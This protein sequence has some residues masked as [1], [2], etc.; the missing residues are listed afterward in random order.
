M[1]K[2]SL[3]IIS[4]FAI[5]ILLSGCLQEEEK[6][7]EHI[8][9]P[10]EEKNKTQEN[11]TSYYPS[12][13]TSERIS[14]P[15]KNFELSFVNVGYGDATIILSK[16]KVILIDTAS[17]ESKDILMA[18]L[19]RR[20][21]K[22]IDLLILSAPEDERFSGNLKDIIDLYKID[23]IW[24]PSKIYLEK[25]LPYLKET[26]IQEVQFGKTYIYDKLKIFVLN[27]VDNNNIY[28]P[29]SDSLVLKVSYNELC[30]I[31]FSKSK[32]GGT[33]RGG[34]TNTYTLGTIESKF[35]LKA[36]E[37]NEPLKCD[38]IKLSD[39]GAGDG[40]SYTLLDFIKPKIGIISVGPNPPLNQ[41]P[42]EQM[43]N[44]LM[45]KGISIYTT[46]RLGNIIISSNDGK[47]YTIYTDF[48]RDEKYAEF[49][50]DVAKTSIKYWK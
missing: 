24:T 6:K 7:Q 30:A 32:M 25:Y 35:V 23:T 14:Y 21:I 1:N 13:P 37:V 46:D 5:F 20:D 15:M 9:V 34:G 18:E 17:K 49:L 27:P 29:D 40:A 48:P 3:F 39:H 31:I 26:N 33:G 36:A 50:Y 41:Y 22:K 45:V 12:Q 47:I 8:F 10:L 4:L 2:E 44:K 28:N 19:K 38:I 16:S 11:Q 42:S 43:I